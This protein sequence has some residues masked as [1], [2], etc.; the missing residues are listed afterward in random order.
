MP[1]R[2]FEVYMIS[3]SGKTIKTHIGTKVTPDYSINDSPTFD[4]LLVP[5]GPL[6]A[7]QSISKNKKIIEWIKSQ[8][9]IEY[10]C[11]VSTGAYLL[12]EAGLLAGKK[13][14]THHL[15]LK[16]LQDKYPDTPCDISGKS[17]P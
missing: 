9:S 4:I 11:S 2:P 10:I 13:V 14:T 17:C 16:L 1:T 15:A 6:R 7:I 3:E 5:G 12:G 8:K